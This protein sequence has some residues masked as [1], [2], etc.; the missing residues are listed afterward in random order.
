MEN[1]MGMAWDQVEGFVRHEFA[2]PHPHDDDWDMDA[3][4]IFMLGAIRK[5]AI[6]KH[7]IGT[8]VIV[9]P[10]G[11]FAY[12]GHASKSLHY[13]GRAVDFHI[14]LG[15]KDNVSRGTLNPIRQAGLIYDLT[16]NRYGLG[17]YTWG[18]HLDYREG[19]ED[20]TDATWFYDGEGYRFERYDKFYRTISNACLDPCF[21]ALQEFDEII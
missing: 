19:V 12:D 11:G 21:I 2:P 15:D 5:R 1:P 8:T 14:N 18:C 10:N 16:D 20:R 4:L 9:H 13:R 7:G 6:R 3:S 17:V